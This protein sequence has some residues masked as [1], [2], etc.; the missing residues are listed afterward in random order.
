MRR[1]NV[2]SRGAK[3][4]PDKKNMPGVKAIPEVS[5]TPKKNRLT[6][7]ERA[8][9]GAGLL[10]ILV[11]G[12]LGYWISTL[13]PSLDALVMALIL[14]IVLRAALPQPA[15]S[16]LEPG[17]RFGLKIFV[18]LGIILYGVNLDFTRILNLPVQVIL[19]T[20]L[21]MVLFYI[22]IYWLNSKVWHLPPRLNEL[23]ATGSAICG[24]SAIA[25][26]SPSV[27]AEPE[28]TST[29][30]LAITATGLLALM[31]YPLLKSGLGLSEEAYGL[32]CGAVLHQTGL[33]RA[34]IVNM[35]SSAATFA[36]AV[37]SLRIMML[38]PV[39]IV[40]G[41][42]PTVRGTTETGKASSGRI[43]WMRALGR[44]WFL[45]PFIVLGLLVSLVPQWSGFLLGLKPWASFIFALALGSIGFSVQV[46]SLME[47]GSKPLWVAIC[48]WLGVL[49]FVILGAVL[50][51]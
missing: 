19:I 3:K 46:E 4:T 51:L 30:V 14:G 37:K 7:T 10:V 22:L 26:L 35:S 34:A 21:A 17:A 38:A 12:G 39:A 5:D 29:S 47:Q 1:L 31:V 50:V 36:L 15:V 24:A 23:I 2:L 8:Q 43:N 25:V 13:N 49:V 41:F 28:E 48:G 44:V 11:L 45:L 9:I 33:V 27:E 42:L 6:S 20:L 18:P 32:L 40:T 16:F